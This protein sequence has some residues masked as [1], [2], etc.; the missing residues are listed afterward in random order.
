MADV[1]VI[2]DQA[3]PK[4]VQETGRRGDDEIIRAGNPKYKVVSVNG[5]T[6]ASGKRR[7]GFTPGQIATAQTSVRVLYQGT[8]CPAVANSLRPS[9]PT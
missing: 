6:G 9:C 5:T 7:R 8:N 4:W 2:E 3:I 1:K